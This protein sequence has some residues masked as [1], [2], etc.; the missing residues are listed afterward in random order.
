MATDAKTEVTPTNDNDQPSNKV[1]GKSDDKCIGNRRIRTILLS[2]L[3]FAFA[4]FAFSYILLNAEDAS[5]F[6]ESLSH[7]A[8]LIVAGL[9]FC[10]IFLL[11]QT[12]L[13]FIPSCNPST[14]C[15]ARIPG[16]GNIFGGTLYLCGWIYYISTEKYLEDY[17]ELPADIQRD[18][19]AFCFVIFLSV[20]SIKYVP[21]NHSAI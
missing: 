16:I 19:D 6:D 7:A 14:N 17:N 15:K 1:K 12:I 10:I 20:I 2:A 4:I 5:E 21:Y 9:I 8:N 13:L 11:I 3:L 18:L